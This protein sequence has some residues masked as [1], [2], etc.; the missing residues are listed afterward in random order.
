M[1][2][3]M[4]DLSA[5]FQTRHSQVAVEVSGGGSALGLEMVAEDHLDMGLSC[6]LPDAPPLDWNPR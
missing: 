2:P 3:L 6:W 5:A 4:Q 1:A